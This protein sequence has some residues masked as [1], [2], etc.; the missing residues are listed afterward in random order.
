M[1]NE[2]N[3][4]IIAPTRRMIFNGIGSSALNLKTARL[5]AASVAGREALTMGSTYR[6]S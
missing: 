5:K 2:E 4:N 3:K 6:L 1:K